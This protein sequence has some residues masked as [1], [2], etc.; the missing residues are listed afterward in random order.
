MDFNSK[1]AAVMEKREKE[2]ASKS[3]KST[4]FLDVRK[5]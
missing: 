5:Y 4:K 3:Q 1:V 2:K